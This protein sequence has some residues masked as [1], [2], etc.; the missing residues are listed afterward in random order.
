MDMKGSLSDRL[1]FVN[2]FSHPYELDTCIS[3][4]IYSD[5]F[6]LALSFCFLR[7]LSVSLRHFLP[8]N[9]LECSKGSSKKTILLHPLLN[10][11][12]LLR[13]FLGQ[14]FLVLNMNIRKAQSPQ[15]F[16]SDW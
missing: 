5:M 7:S 13:S 16:F 15:Y 9:E 1:K 11:T 10:H 3:L 12:F 2:E 8:D 4:F 6:A 14:C